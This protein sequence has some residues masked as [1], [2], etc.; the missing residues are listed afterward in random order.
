MEC[1]VHQLVREWQ[2][3]SGTRNRREKIQTAPAVLQS[4]GHLSSHG[5]VAQRIRLGNLLDTHSAVCAKPEGNAQSGGSRY[6]A[7]RGLL[8]L[9]KAWRQRSLPTAI[10]EPSSGATGAL[11]CEN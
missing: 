6:T 4:C 5:G 3:L 10:M 9:G 1:K 8:R 2:R 11:S 7:E